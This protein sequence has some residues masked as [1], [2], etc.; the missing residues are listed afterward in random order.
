MQINWTI[1]CNFVKSNN[2]VVVTSSDLPN[3]QSK[4][5]N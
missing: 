1:F 3:N 2:E 5:P 4:I